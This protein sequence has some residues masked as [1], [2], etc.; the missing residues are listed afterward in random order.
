MAIGIQQYILWLQIAEKDA[1]LVEAANSENQFSD[2]EFG[3][4]FIK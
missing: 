1:F 2:E 4:F 3:N